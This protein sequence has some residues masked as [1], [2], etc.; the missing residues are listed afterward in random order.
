L[1]CL[2]AGAQ[3]KR[4]DYDAQP[5]K[6]I[7]AAFEC[8]FT[9]MKERQE[10]RLSPLPTIGEGFREWFEVLLTTRRMRRL[11]KLAA[12]LHNKKL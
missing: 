4:R 1:N 12:W 7:K 6:K 10:E 3:K 8:R 9:I 5:I 2:S 11:G